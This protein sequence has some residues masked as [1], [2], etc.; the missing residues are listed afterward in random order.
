MVPSTGDVHAA[1]LATAAQEP[2]EHRELGQVRRE[3]R[4]RAGSRRSAGVPS[5]SSPYHHMTRASDSGDVIT[6]LTAAGSTR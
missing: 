4:R 6:Y 1:L 3:V 5:P 2:G